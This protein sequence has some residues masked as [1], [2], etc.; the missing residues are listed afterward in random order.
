M[1]HLNLH[2]TQLRVLTIYDFT[3]FFFFFHDDY[4]YFK[5]TNT[6]PTQYSELIKNQYF[7]RKSNCQG[8]LS[9]IVIINIWCERGFATTL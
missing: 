5:I 8:S 2:Y 3:F 1:L 4:V 9:N 7:V 6:V